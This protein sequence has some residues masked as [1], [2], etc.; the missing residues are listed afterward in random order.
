MIHPR[1]AMLMYVAGT[2]AGLAT[3]AIIA[4]VLGVGKLRRGTRHQPK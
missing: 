2:V 3:A 1:G 4:P